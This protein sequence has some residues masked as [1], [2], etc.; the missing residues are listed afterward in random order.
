MLF[1]FQI[2]F[3]RME[4]VLQYFL[5]DYLRFHFLYIHFEQRVL[6]VPRVEL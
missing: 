1:I 4:N 6:V 5:T 3:I 2:I